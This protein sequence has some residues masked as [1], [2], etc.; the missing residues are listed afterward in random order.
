MTELR[1][2]D[3]P[4]P[5]AYARWCLPLLGL[6][7]FLVFTVLFWTAPGVYM[8]VMQTLIKVTVPHPFM[9][10]E[11]IPNAIGCF[12]QGV[13]VYV[14]NTCY[15]Y[16]GAGF[17]YSPLFL[18]MTFLPSSS[19]GWQA[20]AV[21]LIVLFFL[22]L[23]T[24]RPPRTLRE[25]MF[26]GAALLSCATALLVER[27][28]ADLLM[29]LLV[30]AAGNAAL[31]SLAVRACGYACL[32]FA[33][34]LKFYPFV[35]LMIAVRERLPV[36]LATMLVAAGSVVALVMLYRS[37]LA[38]MAQN[39]PFASWFSLQFGAGDLPGGLSVLAAQL[40]AKLQGGEP[41][42]YPRLQG[43]LYELL[44]VVFS[45]AAVAGALWFAARFAL[46]RTMRQ[47]PA[48][49]G[50][51]LLLGAAMLCGCFFAGQSVIYRA[52][53]FLLALPALLTLASTAVPARR[54]FMAACRLIVFVLW[55][56]FI[57]WLLQGMRLAKAPPYVAAPF[58]SF[59]DIPFGAVFWL[60]NEISWWLLIT[61]L[62]ATAGAYAWGASPF[63]AGLLTSPRLAN[64]R[65]P[66]AALPGDGRRR[67]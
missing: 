12:W 65:G 3:R 9:D 38:T 10:W 32:I 27:A 28:N 23:A 35:G 37:E 14:N 41:H 49:D 24:L 48:R 52:V 47:L 5:A 19:F 31:R 7:A 16:T 1:R 21:G 42:Q 30:I 18:R 26:M 4:I 6:G 11:W 53:Y 44:K 39:L 46:V 29:F 66:L 15:W 51:F 60:A 64:W 34:L 50:V 2:R 13:D 55:A 8:D 33:G 59:I 25:L 40:V 58:G 20:T 36:L 56:P 67:D 62:L 61:T 22:S 57:E 45:L 43:G 54:W 63:V 17:N